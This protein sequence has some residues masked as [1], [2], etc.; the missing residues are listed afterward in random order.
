M[1]LAPGYVEFD[2]F[3]YLGQFVVYKPHCNFC[4]WR[5]KH[6]KTS[7]AD[8]ANAR[9]EAVDAIWNHARQFHRLQV[10]KEYGL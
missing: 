7:A 6:I 1:S 10:Q 4:N 8:T 3:T 2:D 9:Q 5:L